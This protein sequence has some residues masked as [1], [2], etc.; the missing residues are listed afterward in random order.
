S[1]A[2]AESERRNVVVRTAQ[3]EGS[4]RLETLG[5]QEV[6]AFGRSVRDQWGPQGD[7]LESPGGFA[8]LSEAD[9]PFGRCRPV[10]SGGVSSRPGRG[11]RRHPRLPDLSRAQSMQC[12]ARGR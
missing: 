1:R 8:D 7:A 6:G 11:A 5:L 12:S 2:Y 9:E 4:N 3:L 10:W